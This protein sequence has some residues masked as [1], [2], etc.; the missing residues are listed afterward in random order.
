MLNEKERLRC[1]ALWLAG[2]ADRAMEDGAPMVASALG[3][4]SAELRATASAILARGSAGC[5][6]GLV[7][8]SRESIHGIIDLLRGGWHGDALP[9]EDVADMRQAI[10][11]RIEAAIR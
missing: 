3:M 10:A 2:L 6:E 9:P 1:V 8:V 11:D 7:P 5:G 4:D